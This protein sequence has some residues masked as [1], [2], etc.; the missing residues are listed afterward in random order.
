MENRNGL[1]VKTLVTETNGTAERDA[2]LLMAEKIPG[3]KRLASTQK[4]ARK[5]V[6]DMDSSTSCWRNS[7]SADMFLFHVHF[8]PSTP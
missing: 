8:C 6:P 2:A 3:V 1:L 4:M 7:D 5:T